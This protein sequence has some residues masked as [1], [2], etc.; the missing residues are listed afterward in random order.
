MVPRAEY[1]ALRSAA[2]EELADAAILAQILEDP[3]EE[4]VPADVVRRIAEGE[5]PIRV[6]RMYRGMKAGD[7]ASAAQVAASYLSAIER[8]KKPGSVGALKRTPTH[9]TSHSTNW[10]EPR[11]P[12]TRK[13]HR[14]YAASLVGPPEQ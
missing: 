9:S 3:D 10:S 14:R 12:V 2:H 5:N 6:W 4:W 8:G 7:L 13:R 11:S 1:D